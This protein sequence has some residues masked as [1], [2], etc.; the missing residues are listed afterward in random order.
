[1]ACYRRFPGCVASDS[2]RPSTLLRTETSLWVLRC[3]PTTSSSSLPS[4]QKFRRKSL[5]A[6]GLSRG[7]SRVELTRKAA[8]ARTET[9]VSTSKD[10]SLGNAESFDETSSSTAELESVELF[11]KQ[12][13]VGGVTPT[14]LLY[15]PFGV[16]IALVRMLLWILLL[17]LDTPVFTNN[18]LS[19]AFF[20]TLLGVSVNWKGEEL[21]PASRH[22]LVCNHVTAGDLIILY[23][24]TQR[25]VHLVT[26]ALPRAVTQVNNHRII[27]RHATPATYDSLASPAEGD[28]EHGKPVHLFPE[29]GMTNGDGMMRFTRG[30]VR[31]SREIPVVPMALEVETPF[32]GRL[33]S[34]TLTSSFLANLFWF[35]FYPWIRFTCH[36]L[37]PTS[38]KAD[39]S[40]GHF[41][42]RVQEQ[43]ASHLGIPITETT[44]QRKR[45]LI[46][47]VKEE[48]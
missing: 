37:E 10:E 26:P 15:F 29:G 32:G 40:A 27:F 33:S 16:G 43:I 23:T 7:C 20:Q 44:I 41:A 13:L 3:R 8:N 6:G 5:S 18:K 4:L 48:K 12:H 17:V 25:Y 34:H 30:F 2:R 31:F 46:Q 14:F 24:R 11:P 28:L 21:L 1:M 35:S 19:I 36:V 9:T 45:Q 39:E 22:V 47:S 42:R 38:M